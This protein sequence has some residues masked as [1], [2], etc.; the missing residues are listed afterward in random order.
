[1]P[2]TSTLLPRVPHVNVG[3]SYGPGMEECT[4]VRPSYDQVLYGSDKC[5]FGC[6]STPSDDAKVAL[7]GHYD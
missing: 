5:A 1:M 4:R 3:T 7:L 2:R 6:D